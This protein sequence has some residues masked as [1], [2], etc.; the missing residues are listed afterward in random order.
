[1]NPSGITIIKIRKLIV[2]NRDNL[3][4]VSMFVVPTT[5]KH[6]GQT[7]SIPFISTEHS[8]V[9]ETERGQCRLNTFSQ[10]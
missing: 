4:W 2:Q 5:T 8:N 3:K 10:M 6:F 7:V 9:A 1:M